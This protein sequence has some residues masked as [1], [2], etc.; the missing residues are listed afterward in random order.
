[1][2]RFVISTESGLRYGAMKMCTRDEINDFMTMKF[3][4]RSLML[5]RQVR[6]A[7]IQP[8]RCHTFHAR[9]NVLAMDEFRVLR[10]DGIF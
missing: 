3:N 10:E 8:F 7:E 1:M 2:L 5:Q 6:N 9:C 4:S